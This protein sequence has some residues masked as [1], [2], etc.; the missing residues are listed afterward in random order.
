MSWLTGTSDKHRK[1]TI[2]LSSDSHGD[3]TLTRQL[4]ETFNGPHR[5]MSQPSRLV[6]AGDTAG[7]KPAFRI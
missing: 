3:A 6:P 7:L 4:L 1:S 5:L 2:P